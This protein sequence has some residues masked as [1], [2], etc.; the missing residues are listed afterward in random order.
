MFMAPLVFMDTFPFL[1]LQDS[2]EVRETMTMDTTAIP[3]PPPEPKPVDPPKPTKPKW[4]GAWEDDICVCLIIFSPF[5]FV[6][7]LVM[8]AMAFGVPVID[9]PS[10]ILVLQEG[11]LTKDGWLHRELPVHIHFRTQGHS[12]T[13][14]EANITRV[15]SRAHCPQFIDADDW[16]ARFLSGLNRESGCR[17]GIIDHSNWAIENSMYR[18]T[19]SVRGS[20]FKYSGNLGALYIYGDNVV[21]CGTIYRE[22]WVFGRNATVMLVDE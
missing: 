4:C 8:V 13:E 20:N 22:L 15:P 3:L 18:E 11:R 9:R 17:N 2:S 21:Y 19:L 12:S 5:V 6:L 16:W 14:A 1:Y 7:T 10:P